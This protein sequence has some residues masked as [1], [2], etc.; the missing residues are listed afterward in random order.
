MRAA[1][2][3]LVI[4]LFVAVP[5]VTA[6]RPVE[7]CS[8]QC[9]PTDADVNEI[10]PV[11]AGTTNVVL[12]AHFESI[13]NMAPLNTVPPNETYEPDL[14]RGFLMPT[15]D[16]NTNLCSGQMCAD[17]HFKSNEFTMYL[18]PGLV[19]FED[20]GFRSGCHSPG[21][22]GPL[23]IMGPMTLYFYVGSNAN[24]TS[25]EDGP[26]FLPNVRVAARMEG[27]FHKRVVLARGMSEPTSI[28]AISQDPV[29]YEFKVELTPLAVPDVTIADLMSRGIYFIVEVQQIHSDAAFDT[30]IGQPSWS[31]RTGHKFPPRV[32]VPTKD[33]LRMIDKGSFVRDGNLYAWANVL[34]IYG[35]YDI[36]H[37]SA[38]ARIVA[39]GT[40]KPVDPRALDLLLFKRS[41]NHDGVL[42]PANI[43]WKVHPQYLD[44][45]GSV[46]RVDFEARNLQGTYELAE[47]VP[48]PVTAFTGKGAPGVAPTLVLAWVAFCVLFARVRRVE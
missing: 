11:R 2:A 48:I 1:W 10:V 9:A 39:P 45:G 42:K 21:I 20:E 33:P 30:S 23:D 38:R 34:P 31:V 18:C 41:T 27:D 12:Y 25:A 26:S 36:S 37:E 15:I 47:S 16:T 32:V 8:E 7:S 24:P 35:S 40:E 6:Q 17:F 5:S 4:L 14:N 44:V 3:I 43:T 46:Y 19:T 29:V 13:L 28:T 22:P